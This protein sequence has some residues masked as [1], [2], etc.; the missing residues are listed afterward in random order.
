[1]H[2]ANIVAA[3]L[4][5]AMATAL[6]PSLSHFVVECVYSTLPDPG[7]TCSSLASS[8][9]LTVDA[10]QQLNPDI[11][12]PGLDLSR[13]YCVIGTVTEDTYEPSTTLTTTTS[14]S[15]SIRTTTTSTT[16]AT[17]TIA[18]PSN[19]PTMPGIAQN[20]DGFYQISAGDQ[21]LTIAAKHSITMDQLK[22]W[23][24]AVNDGQFAFFSLFHCLF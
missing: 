22:S 5:P 8:W 21:C 13:S 16:A 1:M 14:T 20:C 7:A 6:S 3:G 15:T 19:S 12:C 17:T 24:S 23:N 10:L 4:A 11:S 9:G 2:L 18:S